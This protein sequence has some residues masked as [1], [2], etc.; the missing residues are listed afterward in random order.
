[1]DAVDLAVF[2]HEVVP[3]YSGGDPASFQMPL[4]AMFGLRSSIII[5]IRSNGG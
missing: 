5:D 3:L 1:M 4:Y 2:V